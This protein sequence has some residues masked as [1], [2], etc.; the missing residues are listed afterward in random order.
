MCFSSV[1]IRA[2]G[3][4]A[5]AAMLNACTAVPGQRMIT[6]ATLVQSGGEYST[7]PQTDLN[8]PIT[9]INLNLIRQMKTDSDSTQLPD[10]VMRLIDPVEDPYKPSSKKDDS[11]R[12]G[13]GDVL[14]ITVWDHPELAAAAG[15]TVESARANDPAPGFV[16]DGT[17]HIHF[18]FTGT[19]PVVGR[20]TQDVQK[21]LQEALGHTYKSPQVTVRVA[22]FRAARVYVDGEV[23]T[24]GD[25]QVND[26]RMT[27]AEAIGRAGGFTQNADQ[28]H[29][30]LIH[31]GTTTRID[32]PKLLRAGH[33]PSDIA[34]QPRDIVRVA[35]RD[36]TGVYVMGEVNRPATITPMRDG[37][38]TL[39]EALSQAGSLNLNTAE[40][41]QLYVI[42]GMNVGQDT[43]P[44]NFQVYHLD[45]TSPVSMLLANQFQLKPEDIVYVDN[46]PL[47]KFYRVL[48]MLMPAIN[49]GLTAAILTK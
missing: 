24:P 21:D 11:Y 27:L 29:I 23:H 5:L 40:A 42:R 34:L 35:A 3:I 41:R 15:T 39:S 48:N 37:R 30:D 44:A 17:G 4:L 32:L 31:N 8:V 22:S 25:V 46:G 2:A 47:V 10:Q 43:Q 12:I 7:E 13:R 20:T 9:D 14:Q 45:A 33:N 1:S 19:I 6:P 16:V 28:S 49:A 38:L 36:D 26:I 18:P